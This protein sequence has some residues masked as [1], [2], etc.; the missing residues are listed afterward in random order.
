MR[1]PLKGSNRLKIALRQAAISAT[2]RKLG[3]IIWTMITKKVPYNPP[4]EYLY[5][6]QKRKW[7]LQEE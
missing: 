3:V 5:L 6:D 7:D 4:I 2:A 1:F